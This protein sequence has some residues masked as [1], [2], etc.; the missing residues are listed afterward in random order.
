MSKTNYILHLNATF[1][2]IFEDDRLNPTHI[3]LYMA[4]FQFW[5]LNRFVNPFTIAR[6]D[7]L[8]LSK[9]R[10]RVTYLK[11]LKDLQAWN[12]IIYQPSRNPI[13][14]SKVSI[15]NI[16]STKWKSNLN[17]TN[18][19]VLDT[20]KQDDKT[21]TNNDQQL[22]KSCTNNEHQLDNT[23][24]NNVQQVSE[25]C[26]NNVQRLYPSKTYKQKHINSKGPPQNSNLVIDFFLEEKSTELEARKFWNFYESIGWKSGKSI[27]TNWQA[28]A[29]K[30]IL[31]SEQ[32]NDKPHVQKMNYLH[33]NKNKKYDNPL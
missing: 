16:W 1:A 33:T 4:L 14:G 26:T 2:R 24:T 25:T 31:S 21:Y 29:R 19:L 8:V 10:S 32:S 30:W 20:P 27:I 3:S 22:D 13:V 6:E 7:V 12:Y 5:N 17:L 11:C 18:N 28:S 15:I 9:I 23:C